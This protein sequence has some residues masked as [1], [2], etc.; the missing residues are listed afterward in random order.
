MGLA[1]TS[2]AL[3]CATRPNSSIFDH[4]IKNTDPAPQASRK[5]LGGIIPSCSSTENSVAVWPSILPVRHFQRKVVISAYLVIPQLESTMASARLADILP[6]N[7]LVIQKTQFMSSLAADQ[8]ARNAFKSSGVIAGPGKKHVDQNR[9]HVDNAV[10][11][12]LERGCREE[13]LVF[14]NGH[15]DGKCGFLPFLSELRAMSTWSSAMPWHVFAEFVYRI[16]RAKVEWMRSPQFPFSA[17]EHSATARQVDALMEKLPDF[18][19]RCQAYIGSPYM[20]ALHAREN[21]AEIERAVIDRVPHGGVSS[22]VED[23]TEAAGPVYFL[24]ECWDQV[25]SRGVEA[26]KID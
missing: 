20:I 10:A 21:L 1:H 24:D 13:L 17:A 22:S 11:E 14:Y 3:S 8:K 12:L 5:S 15:P 6:R 9:L 18:W 7:G 2:S 16:V 23:G 19:E 4:T 25:I 26:M